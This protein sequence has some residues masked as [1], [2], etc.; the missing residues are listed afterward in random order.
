V[1]AQQVKLDISETQREN[2]EQDTQLNERKADPSSS[3]FRRVKSSFSQMF[4]DD[5][6]SMKRRYS[7][8]ISEEKMDKSDI[9]NSKEI[10]KKQEQAKQE[11]YKDPPV[12][13]CEMIYTRLS[14]DDILEDE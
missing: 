8:S 11:L 14:K 1:P 10:L 13:S 4:S 7:P 5:N 12:D 2:Y 3:W 9:I 6:P